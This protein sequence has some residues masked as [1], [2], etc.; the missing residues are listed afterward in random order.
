MKVTI[1]P[2]VIGAFGTETNWLLKG[3]ED[4]EVGRRMETIQTTASIVDNGQNTE[5]NPGD[6]KRLAV[7]QT[8]V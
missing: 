1:L 2:I 5:K 8:L 6:L 4:L 7:I 3:M